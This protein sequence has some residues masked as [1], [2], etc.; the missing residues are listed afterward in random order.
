MLT[1]G[2]AAAAWWA[3]RPPDD[4]AA[5]LPSIPEGGTP[6]DVQSDGTTTMPLTL[7]A[8]DGT[9]LPGDPAAPVTTAGP[10]V[11]NPAVAGPGAATPT[12]PRATSPTSPTSPAA[13]ATPTTAAPP[14]T[15]ATPAT[16]APATT[17]ATTTTK[18]PTT[19]SP[20][21]QTTL[22]PGAR[23]PSDWPPGKPIPPVP[24]GC[25]Q[26]VLEDNGVWNCQ[27]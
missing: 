3:L 27:H 16:T 12:A 22:P 10:D 14:A 23:I 1:V 13:P 15:T 19:T 6:H 2:M 18:P 11:T 8:L 25:K 26:P 7:I 4:A 17:P 24:E 21:T 20:S 9:T 5:T